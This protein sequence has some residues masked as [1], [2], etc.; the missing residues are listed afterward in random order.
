VEALI[1]A[2]ATAF[3]AA[4]LEATRIDAPNIVILLSSGGRATN[5][6]EC[7]PI[8]VKKDQALLVATLIR[9]GATNVGEALT[10]AYEL[11]R[12]Y[13]AALLEQMVDE[14][15][16]ATGRLREMVDETKDSDLLE[17]LTAISPVG[18]TVAALADACQRRRTKLSLLLAESG[19]IDWETAFDVCLKSGFDRLV[20]YL[21][22]KRCSEVTAKRCSEVT[23]KRCSEGLVKAAEEGC[24][25][26]RQYLRNE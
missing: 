7:L 18:D 23:A 16:V 20:Y 26:V 8:A 14:S 1:R 15:M 17:Y 10:L 6:N 24:E 12:P 21:V 3:N 22:V 5:H 11:K 4:L 25:A 9:E 2:G 19:R 13:T